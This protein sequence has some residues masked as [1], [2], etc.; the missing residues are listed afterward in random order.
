ML[1]MLESRDSDEGLLASKFCADEK[2]E[3]RLKT[4][5]KRH[6]GR[7]GCAGGEGAQGKKLKSRSSGKLWEL[8]V[9]REFMTGK[10]F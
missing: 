2:N 7:I 10:L 3:M 9:R 8:R 6:H 1:R 5:R 4:H